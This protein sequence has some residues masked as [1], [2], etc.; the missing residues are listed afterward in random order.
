LTSFDYQSGGNMPRVVIA[1]V[2][3]VL[4]ASLCRAQTTVDTVLTMSDGAKLDLLYCIPSTA[5]PAAGY[6]GVVIVHGFQGSK[7]SV[8]ANA[9]DYAK[10]G[11]V[12][13]GY[14]VRGQGGSE[15]EFDFFTSERV[16]ADL[17]AMIDF[18]KALP[19]VNDDRVGVLGGSQGGIHAW[20]AAAHHLGARAVASIIANG[21][22]EE[23]WAANNAM[24]W[25]FAR[26]I[27]FATGVRFKP[28]LKDSINLATTTGN[29]DWVK[30]YLEQYSTRNLEPAVTTPTMIA[31][32]YFDGFF[33]PSSALRQFVRI[34][35]PK[36]MFLYPAQH[37]LPDDPQ[38]YD[39]VVNAITRWFN[40]WLKDDQSER[41]IVSQDSAV[42]MFDGATAEA[43]VFSLADSTYWLNPPAAPPAGLSARTWYLSNS[44]LTDTAPADGQKAFTYVNILGGTTLAYRTAPFAADQRIA[45]TFGQATLASDGTA[46]MYQVNLQLFD[47][48]PSTGK[49]LPVTRGHYEF[50]QN[51]SGVRDVATFELN[52]VSHTVRAGHVLEAHVHGGIP[53]APN[54]T[55][56]FGNVVLGPVSNSNNTMYYG[57]AQPSR[58]TLYFH[59]ANATGVEQTTAAVSP[60][61]ISIYPNPLGGASASGSERATIRVAQVSPAMRLTICDALGR[62]VSVIDAGESR[63]GAHSFS[64]DVSALPAGFYRVVLADGARLARRSLVVVR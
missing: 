51:V 35:A 27:A 20:A 5:P 41:N 38:T 60:G 39:H 2:L 57:G 46:A 12:T 10:L 28:G 47:I 36:R 3:S 16:L 11:Y 55:N 6:P 48:D 50:K 40:Y 13:L 7:E 52:T 53:V 37:S 62:V 17:K 26:A 14:S 33:N 18:T 44:G 8:R 58:F 61:V 1:F 15:G 56:D 19:G 64:V 22:F 9:V 29:I 24:N 31:V 32:S 4:L 54:A 59:D 49:S 42:I 63:P 30:R 23:D 45:G 25:T 34:P 21:R 43:H